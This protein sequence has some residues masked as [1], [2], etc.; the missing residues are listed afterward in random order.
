[1][2]TLLREQLVDRPAED[3]VP[4]PWRGFAPGPWRHEVNVRDF[5]VRNVTPYAGDA[6]FLGHATGRTKV[7][8]AKV[9]ELLKK[10][11]AAKGGVLDADTETVSSIT[12]H[13]PGY[14]DREN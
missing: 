12:A 14:I 13:G 4:L 2:D 1:M 6:A 7:L 8:W 10:E 9:S 3:A 5:I 11:R